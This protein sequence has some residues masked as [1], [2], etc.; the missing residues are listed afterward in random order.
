M[1]LHMNT[2]QRHRKILYEQRAWLKMMEGYVYNARDAGYKVV[3]VEGGGWM[4]DNEFLSSDSLLYLFLV[5]RGVV[6]VHKLQESR[7]TGVRG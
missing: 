2:H 1:V 7:M 6:S 3:P 4:I 5:D